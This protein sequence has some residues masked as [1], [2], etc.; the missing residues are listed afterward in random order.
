[1]NKNMIKRSCFFGNEERVIAETAKKIKQ[2]L[3]TDFNLFCVSNTRH[4]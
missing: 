3:H 4:S 1:M 2:K